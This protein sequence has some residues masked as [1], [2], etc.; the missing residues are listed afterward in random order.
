MLKHC[1][2]TTLIMKP[3]MTTSENYK[4]DLGIFGAEQ[5]HSD[6][7]SFAHRSRYTKKKLRGTV[8]NFI[9]KCRKMVGLLGCASSA[10]AYAPASPMPSLAS[11]SHATSSSRVVEE[12]EEEE[13]EKEE[14]HEEEYDDD[15][16]PPPTKTIH[17]EKRNVPKRD[18]A[19][20]SPFQRMC[21]PHRK[22]KAGEIRSKNKDDRT[23]KKG[24]SK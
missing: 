20:P 7:L 19:S 15:D 4:A 3:T 13:D 12:D 1:A 8:K 10:D 24:R 2:M 18:W 9:N 23:S 16:G 11:S 5:K 17:L 6:A 22:K 14:D 21:P